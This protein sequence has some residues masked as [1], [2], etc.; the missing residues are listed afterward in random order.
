MVI[1]LQAKSWLYT[2]QV[3]SSFLIFLGVQYQ[4]KILVK[5]NETNGNL[6]VEIQAQFAHCGLEKPDY[7]CFD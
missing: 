1:L 2:H 7:Y 6:W 5:A 3:S 4:L